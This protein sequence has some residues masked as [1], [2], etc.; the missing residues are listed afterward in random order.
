MAAVWQIVTTGTDRQRRDAINILIET[1]RKLYGL[2]ADGD[3]GRDAADPRSPARRTTTTRR[4]RERAVTAEPAGSR[5]ELRIGDADRT[6]AAEELAEHYAQGRISAGGAQRP[7]RPDLGGQDPRRPDAGLHRP[8]RQR[9][10][11]PG[12][13]RLGR[14]PGHR[15]GPAARRPPVPDAAVR[16]PTLRPSAVHRHRRPTSWFGALP[17]LIKVVL[18]VALVMLVIAHLPLILI[19][20]R[21]LGGPRAPGR[22][23]APPT[24]PS[25]PLVTAGRF[26]PR[27][28]GQPLR[29][30]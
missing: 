8:A 14:P 1:R 5:R 16:P 26:H 27:G 20:G 28:G 17:V 6:A 10:P 25:A 30:E 29:R 4:R 24:R 2:L 23:L 22:R 18:V 11:R 19:G 13:V 15:P 12:D 9:V 3:D 7:A 21:D